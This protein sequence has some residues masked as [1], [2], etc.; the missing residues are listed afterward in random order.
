MNEKVRTRRAQKLGQE[1]RVRRR[2]PRGMT[3][4]FHKIVASNGDRSFRTARANEKDIP[5]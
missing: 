4:V 3:F 5:W 1:G 2:K